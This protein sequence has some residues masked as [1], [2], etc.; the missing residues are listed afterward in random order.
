MAVRAAMAL[1]LLELLSCAWGCSG[2][3]MFVCRAI[4]HGDFLRFKWNSVPCRLK[5]WLYRAT[6]PEHASPACLV[7]PVLEDKTP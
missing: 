5:L 2:L 6:I 3:S 7:Q 1:G 4:G